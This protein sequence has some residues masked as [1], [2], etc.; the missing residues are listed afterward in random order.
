M[1]GEASGY[2]IQVMYTDDGIVVRFADVEELPSLEQLIPDPDDVE[3]LLTD[4]LAGTSL[5]AGLF[6]E[7]A[8][9]SLLLRR[10]RPGQRSPLWAQR[11]KAQDLLASVRQ[12]PNFPIVIETY[13]QALA[14]VFDLPAFRQV[15]TDLRNRSVT[16]D[17]VETGSASPFARSL[18]FAYVAAYLYEQDAP[19]AERKAQALTLDRGLLG[20][21]LGQAELRELIDTRVLEA[22]EFDLQHL[23]PE[24]R[25]RD[26]DDVHDLLRRLGDLSPGE[27]AERLQDVRDRDALAADWLGALHAQRR[28]VSVKLA[29]E[30]RWIATE[31]AGLYRDALGV[32]TPPGIPDAFLKP[33]DAPLE[34]LFRRYARHRG[35]FLTRDVAARFELR[36]AQVTPV[37]TL[38]EKAGV[39]VRGEIRPG[40]AELDWCDAE[41][42][43]RLKRR[44]LAQLRDEV[45]AV[46]TPAFASFLPRW[47]GVDDER[48]G[49]ERLREVIG[50]LQALALP[51]SLWRDVILPSR[52][53]GFRHDMLDMMAASGEVVWVGR[54][55]SGQRDGRVAL[56]LRSQVRDLLM[57]PELLE[58]PEP[59]HESILE[60]LE[61]NGASFLLEIE[62]DVASRG[63]AV[64]PQAFREALW[65]LVWAGLI[66]ND[67]FG[68]LRELARTGPRKRRRRGG[69]GP[70]VTGG[71]WAL[72][73]NLVRES[74][75]PTQQTVA[76]TQLLLDRYGIVSRDC[77][78]N[79][80]FPGGFGPIYKVLRELEEQGRVRRGYFVEGLAGAQ[81]AYAG[82][83][84][85]LRAGREQVEER[86]HVVT[87]ADIQL[88]SAMDP[89][90]PFGALVP[91]PEVAEPGQG[92]PRRVGGAWIVLAR[93]RPVLY[94][95]ARGKRILTFPGAL[96]DEE[97]ALAAGL[98]ALHQLPRSALRGQFVVEQID[99]GPPRESGHLDAFREAGFSNDY[100]GL[101]LSDSP[102]F[103]SAN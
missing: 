12:Y 40:G 7:N 99:G 20:E 31:D 64:T 2:E 32:A 61:R 22:L 82:A 47:H 19:L 85:R 86:D 65:D 98:K 66:T 50:Q 70:V 30:T 44:N 69:A 97:G 103:G 83:V 77:L 9:R 51:W 5:F 41:V 39:L 78:A 76:R 81:F 101:I 37:L 42:L 75:N 6:R 27:V 23:S 95:A 100:R 84:D 73:T 17:D 35:P 18:V 80:D 94:I 49:M 15:L 58:E 57:R 13:R 93:G 46:G 1:L 90:N 63:I 36:P 62:N 91:W 4:Q 26:A 34:R 68:P 24:R 79:E 43:R 89:A 48:Q 96:R 60:S 74:S 54:G 3:D 72:V 16:V 67:T 56:Y 52:V 14:D 102:D 87:P 33:V 71:R 59:L 45:A 92:K 29:G 11:I 28:A 8:V 88:L 10:R 55:A 21:L 38:L 25:A 53:Q